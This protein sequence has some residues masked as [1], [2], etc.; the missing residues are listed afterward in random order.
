MVCPCEVLVSADDE[1][2][3]R[4]AAEVVAGEAWRVE[5][6]FSRYRHDNIVHAINNAGGRPVTVDEETARL[7]DFA[8]DCYDSSDGLFDVTSGVLRRV[9]QFDGSDHLPTPATVHEALQ[10]VG[11][12]RVRWQAPLFSMPAGMQIDFGGIGKEYACDRAAEIGSAAANAPVLVNF[13]GDIRVT[14]PRCDGRPWHIAIEN[15]A[16]DSIPPLVEIRRGAV[17]T[18]GDL[19][20]YLLKDGVRYG[21]ILDPRTGWPVQDAP[22]SVTVLE[23][24]CTQ[25]G[26]LS[27][28]AILHGAGAERFL[29]ELNVKH[30]VVR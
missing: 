16:P 26:L 29:A 13:G 17:T 12:G 8:A 9:W 7:L 5:Q 1:A 30:W 2:S 11:W 22:R 4:R 23:V 24:N 28:L 20:R 19:R 25:A 21:H 27:T 15:V 6:K 3:A 14:G 18:S 10:M